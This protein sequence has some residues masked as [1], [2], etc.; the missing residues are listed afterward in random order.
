MFVGVCM[1]MTVFTGLS[2]SACIASTKEQ[3]IFLCAVVA[4]HDWL[5]KFVLHPRRWW[6]IVVVV[7]GLC[8]SYRYCHATHALAALTGLRANNNSRSYY[9]VSSLI[10]ERMKAYLDAA[11]M[12]PFQDYRWYCRQS[13]D[14]GSTMRGK[15]EI[16]GGSADIRTCLS[17]TK[18]RDQLLV[19]HMSNVK[20][21]FTV[22][23]CVYVR[24]S[25]LEKKL[26]Q[27]TSSD[28]RSW[29][30]QQVSTHPR[31]KSRRSCAS[32]IFVT[33]ILLPNEPHWVCTYSSI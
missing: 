3:T 14:S 22:R 7:L 23:L 33:Q 12:R 29:R 4:K 31:F 27:T 17:Q 5:P 19:E 1:F 18:A 26:N 28:K 20:S 9:Q 24:R 32:R 16:R 6:G 10:A 11:D 15:R 13:S 2:V 21:V 8:Y 30:W 25:V